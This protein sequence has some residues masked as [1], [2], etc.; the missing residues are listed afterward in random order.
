MDDK[1]GRGKIGIL[2]ETWKRIAERELDELGWKIL[3]AA[4]R[5]AAD[6]QK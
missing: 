6:R 1:W 5:A 2:K 4:A 3:E